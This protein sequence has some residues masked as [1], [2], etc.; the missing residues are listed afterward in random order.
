LKHELIL[1]RGI[2]TTAHPLRPAI[3]LQ[4]IVANSDDANRSPE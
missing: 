3:R 1:V 4:T 2:T